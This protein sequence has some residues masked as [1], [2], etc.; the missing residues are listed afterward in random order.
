[1]T[2]STKRIAVSFVALA[3]A[4]GTVAFA[5]CTAT[6]GTG[7][8]ADGGSGPPATVDASTTDSAVPDSAVPDSAVVVADAGADA[9]ADAG[10]ACVGNKQ[11][12]GD[13]VSAACQAALNTAC[14][15]ELKG[16]FN[17]VVTPVDG[18]ANDDCATYAACV[19]VA[20]AQPTPAQQQAAQAECDLGAP[21]NVQNAYDAIVTCATNNPTA[22]AACQ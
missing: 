8:D 20:R 14:C 22:N 13:F 6:N 9:D 12:G 18:G 1:M 5:G 11:T 15:A 2:L 7:N 21:Q 3:V 19:D 17:L 10:G 4:A 16:C